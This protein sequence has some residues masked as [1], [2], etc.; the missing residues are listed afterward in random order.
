MPAEAGE[1]DISSLLAACG[2]TAFSGDGSDW[3]S[4]GLESAS[5]PDSAREAALASLQLAASPRKKLLAG[6]G[7]GRGAKRH[8]LDTLIQDLDLTANSL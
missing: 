1:H 8:D 7:E 6:D 4:V 5:P 2:L 3:K